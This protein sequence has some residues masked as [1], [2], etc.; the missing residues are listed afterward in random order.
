MTINYRLGVWGFL[1]HPWLREE[2]G[3]SGNYGILDQIAALKWVQENIAAF[4]GDKDN[5]TVFG[6]SAGAMSVLTLISSELSRGLFARAIVQ[7]GLGLESGRPLEQAEEDGLAF[8]QAAGAEN[9]EQLRCLPTE[10]VSRLAGPLIAKGFRS[11]G[12]LTFSPVVDGYVLKEGY[13]ELWRQGKTHP[14]PYLIGCNREDMLSDPQALARGE[15]GGMYHAMEDFARQ[16]CPN[17][18]VYAYYFTRQMPG[19][20][21]GAFHSAE[22]WYVFGTMDRAWRPWTPEDHRLCDQILSYWTRFMKTGNPNEDGQESWP[23]YTLEAPHIQ[24]LDVKSGT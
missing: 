6:Q 7:S 17:A 20:N 22:L 9:L 3:V 11:G 18:P 5:V 21:S 16:A 10:Q 14:V 24:I 8:S 2:S 4:G 1:A 15:Q 23:A 12:G 19:D 13:H